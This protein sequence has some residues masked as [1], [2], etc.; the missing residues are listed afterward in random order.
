MKTKFSM[1]M[2]VILSGIILFMGASMYNG[3]KKTAAEPAVSSRN[4]YICMDNPVDPLFADALSDSHIMAEYRQI[5]E[6]Y[7]NTWKTQYDHIMKDIRKKCRY[8]EDIA[9]YDLFA[10]EIDQGFD[11]LQPL[12][13]D[14]MLHNYDIPEC[15]EKHSQGNGTQQALLMYKG[16]MY[17][18]ACMFFISLYDKNDFRFPTDEVERSLSEI[19][20][21]KK[22]IEKAAF[23]LQN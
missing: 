22:T 1:C 2:N 17:R 8:K 4:Y 13:L 15:P 11:R 10:K 20:Q 21:E 6:L 12:I 3:N 19:L 14:E 9:D 18:N 23:S 5:Q 16:T 7:Y